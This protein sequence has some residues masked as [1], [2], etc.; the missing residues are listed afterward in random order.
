MHDVTDEDTVRSV[1]G[2]APASSEDDFNTVNAKMKSK[3]IFTKVTDA[4]MRGTLLDNICG[5]HGFIPSL[6]LVFEGLKTLEPACEVLKK[7]VGDPRKT[8]RQALMDSYTGEL[9]APV[10][11]S[12]GVTVPH[13][14]GDSELCK[15]FLYLQIWVFCLR[16]FHYLT[17]FTPRKDRSQPKPRAR[18]PNPAL[19]HYLGQLA[20]ESGFRTS[21][22]LEW[23][24]RRP[25]ES[26]IAHFREL[27]E[28]GLINVPKQNLDRMS[29][30]AAS[31]GG[32]KQRTKRMHPSLFA[33]TTCDR[34][35][36]F[37]RPYDSDYK[38]DRKT[39][40]LINF[41]KQ[42]EKSGPYVT[43]SFARRE[44]L[45]LFFRSPASQL[46]ALKPLEISDHPMDDSDCE[47]D[48]E[49]TPSSVAADPEL[50]SRENA[51]LITR[52]R[53]LEADLESATLENQNLKRHQC[54]A[55]TVTA[56]HL[57]TLQTENETL[58]GHIKQLE[59]RIECGCQELIQMKAHCCPEISGVAQMRIDKLQVE[60]ESLQRQAK[61]QEDRIGLGC[62]EAIQLK[63]E[64]ESLQGQIKLLEDRIER[65][66]QELTQL[67]AH[68]C[69]D[70]SSAAQNDLDEAHRRIE[71]IS[72]LNSALGS[73][74]QTLEASVHKLGEE[75][76]DLKTEQQHNRVAFADFED[77]GKRWEQAVRRREYSMKSAVETITAMVNI[78]VN[79]DPNH[80]EA[81]YA[82]IHARY[83]ACDTEVV[84]VHFAIA[85]RI[86]AFQFDRRDLY[87][88]IE[89]I[90][91]EVKRCKSLDGTCLADFAKSINFRDAE[92]FK[93][94]DV[95]KSICF[96]DAESESIWGPG[97]RKR[98]ALGPIDVRATKR[99]SLMRNATRRVENGEL[100]ADNDLVR[101]KEPLSES[102]EE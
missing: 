36:R 32:Q 67:K 44:L 29:V 38:E 16:N 20:V 27:I 50:L 28:V 83:M 11:L 56:D 18:Q 48:V 102:G 57:S 51:A 15:W 49:G 8:I 23:A 35:R 81:A 59:D 68:R 63:A 61:L 13:S 93:N 92:A 99:L 40:F 3:A 21:I 88:I 74:K 24:E 77:L 58:R 47:L 9:T 64:N 89:K 71:K 78:Y 95:G 86:Y 41:M 82:E 94:F 34:D 98:S 19:E 14:W 39:F 25:G 33:Y 100:R 85:K 65:G 5:V 6:R 96:I 4:A 72:N 30:L 70:V 76:R 73:D 60:N 42:V 10:E 84:Y 80:L 79:A 69:P 90:A 7:L 1:E 75:V 22:A 37:G 26:L 87:T 62:Q 45:E 55:V 53:Q 91:P 17:S 101:T 97:R 12:N 2:L 52:L 31:N 54:P 66:C 46:E 43:F